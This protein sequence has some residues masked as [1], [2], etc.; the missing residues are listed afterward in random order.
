VK[1]A[2][3]ERLLDFDA[4]RLSDFDEARARQTL[5]GPDG[6]VYRNH[7]L[8]ALWIEQWR[9]RV[10]KNIDDYVIDGGF[11]GFDYALREVAAHLRQG[12]FVPGGE[13]HD[14]ALNEAHGR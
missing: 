4:E 7:L 8:I 10:S 13:L 12:D 5:N 6:G 14:M 3:I 11:D 1:E 2:A 9:I